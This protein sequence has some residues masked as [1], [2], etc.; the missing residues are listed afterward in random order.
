MEA[1]AGTD[2]FKDAIVTLPGWGIGLVCALVF[3]SLLLVAGLALSNA[4]AEI[5]GAALQLLVVL[6]PLTFAVI[7]A[8]ALRFTGTRQIDWLVTRFLEKTLLERFTIWTS[9]AAAD[10]SG[11]D[12][13][14]FDHVSLLGKTHGRSYAFYE[15]TSGASRMKVGIKMNVFNFEVFS[16]LPVSLPAPEAARIDE[17]LIVTAHSLEALKGHPVLRHFMGLMQGSVSE[18]YEM[19]FS[20]SAAPGQG[21]QRHDMHVSLRQKVRENFLASPFMKR[22]FA[23]DAAI[24]IGVLF[25][26]WRDSGLAV[27]DAATPAAP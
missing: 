16:T 22:Y 3:G 25:R 20:F 6:I 26:E 19:K 27:A 23:E 7:A 11:G 1:P 15:F 14:P 4:G 18:G 10:L 2:G 21:P 13:Y 9:T 8:V 5:R 17:S 24:A 12:G